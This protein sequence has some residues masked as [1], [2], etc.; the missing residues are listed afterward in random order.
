MTLCYSPQIGREC[1]DPSGIVHS[2]HLRTSVHGSLGDCLEEDQPQN[3]GR[4]P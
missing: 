2:V 4:E 1:Q 3:Q